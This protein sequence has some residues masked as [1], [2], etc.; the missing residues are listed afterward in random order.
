VERQYIKHP[1]TWL[2]G[3]HYDDESPAPEPSGSGRRMPYQ[4]PTDHDLYDED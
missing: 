2:N 1:K 4:S 3:G